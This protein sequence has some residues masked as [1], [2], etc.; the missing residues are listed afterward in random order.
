MET[1]APAPHPAPAANGAPPRARKSR[2]PE[3]VDAL[4]A[5][6]KALLPLAC[7]L[8]PLGPEK[9]SKESRCALLAFKLAE[10]HEYWSAKFFE[11]RAEEPAGQEGEGW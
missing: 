3:Q 11:E 10:A 8:K 2:T 7:Q 6:A 9:L 1:T 5:H 4:R